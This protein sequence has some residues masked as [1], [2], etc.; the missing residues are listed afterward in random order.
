M[1]TEAIRTFGSCYDLE[2][3]NKLNIFDRRLFTMNKILEKVTSN[4]AMP[5][6]KKQPITNTQQYF[7]KHD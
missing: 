2:E 5:P 3:E 4:S 1:Q 7:M 6:K